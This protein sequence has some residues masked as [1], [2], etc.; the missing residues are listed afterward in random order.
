MA[1]VPYSFQIPECTNDNEQLV[2]SL[3]QIKVCVKFE[4][5]RIVYKIQSQFREYAHLE[6]YPNKKSPLFQ[7]G[8]S[9]Q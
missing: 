7:G 8:F 1:I 9:I 3:A 2:K 6:W 5:E 4:T